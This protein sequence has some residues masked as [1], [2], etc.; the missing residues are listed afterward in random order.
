[1]KIESRHTSLSS[2]L[3]TLC[4]LAFIA[5]ASMA[6]TT[7]GF[8]TKGCVEVGGNAAFQ[9]LSYTSSYYTGETITSLSFGPYVGYFAS[10]GIEL[11]LNPFS[12]EH[13]SSGGYSI[14]QFMIVAAPSY[15]FIT[16]GMAYPFIEGLIGY[17]ST[18]ESGGYA[19]SHG[20]IWGGRGGVKLA[21]ATQALLNLAIEFKRTSWSQSG[22]PVMSNTNDFSISGGFTVWF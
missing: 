20:I 6:Q 5:P 3:R 13:T 12:V 1:M 21:V 9:S 19:T 2:V 15:N 11:A 14:T 22:E 10:D 18:A 16:G 4:I 7:K 17:T 8:A